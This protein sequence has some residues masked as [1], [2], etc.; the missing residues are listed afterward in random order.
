MKTSRRKFIKSTGFISVGFSLMG[1]SLVSCTDSNSRASGGYLAATSG[2]KNRIDSWLQVL[3]DGRIRVL[4]GRM[5]LGQ[6]VSTAMMQVAAEELN[7][8]PDFVEVNLAETGVTP[9]EGYT[10]GSRSME[11]GAKSVRYAAA[12]ARVN[13]LEL[14]AKKWD[15]T[16]GELKIEQGK[17]SGNSQELTFFQLLGGNQIHI[18]LDESVELWGK[19][20]RKWVGRP[21]PRKDIREMVQGKRAYVQDLCFPDMVHARIVRPSSYT[22]KLKSFDKKQLETLPGH[23]KTV[24][25]GSFIGLI[26]KEEYQAITL[27]EKAR[28]L[29]TWETAKQL[30][31][32]IS[33]KEHIKSLKTEISTEEDSGNWKNA[34]EQ[35]PIR[36]QAEFYKPYIMHAANGPSCAVAYFK[37][38]KLKVWSHSQGVYPLQQTLSSILDLP[39]E[40]IYVKGVPGSGCYGHNGA[41]DV[42]AEAAL[43]AKYYPGTHVRL[44]WMRE[45]EHGWE[46]YGTAM[47][48]KLQAGLDRNGKIQ[49]WKYDFWSDGHSSRPRGNPENL[50]PARF[51]DAGHGVPGMGSKGG[52]VRNSKPYYPIANLNI[53]VNMFQGPLRASALRGLGAY[54]NIF[55]IEC[56]MDEL[57][58]KAKMDP[59]QFRIDHLED[60]RGKACLDKLR[61]MTKG[62]PM[63][64]QEGVGYAYSRYK[65]SAAHCAVAAH[66]AVDAESGKVHLLKMWAVVDAG[67]CINL[68]GIK[69][70]IEGGMIQSA[71]WALL[72]E[73]KFDAQHV[74]SLDWAGY[75]ILRFPDTPQVE[76]EVID[77]PNEPPLGAGEASQGPAT[78]ALINAI[79]NA[80][81]LRIRDLPVNEKLLMRS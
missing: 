52:A 20:K 69:N 59:I 21:V 75:P 47:L 7:T 13:L 31:Q 58:E 61:N 80:T 8:S 12:T 77:H 5:E 71:S 26:A 40:S 42:A 23:L 60:P 30:P 38:G 44:Q 73:V 79:A 78:A 6:G 68:D 27:M 45:D 72:E 15:A 70:Q 54:A 64:A 10:A 48:M 18:S 56:F 1:S 81:G 37:D 33:L 25:L 14:A 76:V 24:V 34:L 36:H 57:S 3:E 43:L 17:I 4:T 32:N 63:G 50:L 9:D 55:A 65:N 74:T 2:D 28:L 19:S 29:A 51:L 39:V 16:A 41:D 66:L 49:S 62:V 11:Q 35:S 53:T 22:S 46:P 67:E